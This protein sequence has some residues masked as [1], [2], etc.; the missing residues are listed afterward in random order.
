M[1]RSKKSAYMSNKVSILFIDS[2][3]IH[4]IFCKEM[5]TSYE[6]L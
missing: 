1:A 4:N 6:I 5:K 2:K 3:F